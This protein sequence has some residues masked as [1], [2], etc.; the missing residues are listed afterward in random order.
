MKM[1]IMFKYSERRM[2]LHPARVLLAGGLALAALLAIVPVAAQQEAR[3]IQD[4]SFLIEEAYNQENGVI[5]HISLFS[6]FWMSRDM[7]YTFTQEWPAPRRPRH[8]FS[9]TLA[10]VR[11]GAFTGSGVGFGDV[12]LNY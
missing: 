5:Q 3:P 9:Y 10:A 4:N 2:P 7:V 12:V 11:P 6:R 8:Q 1:T